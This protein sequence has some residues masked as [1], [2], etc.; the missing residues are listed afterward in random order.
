[1]VNRL[2]GGLSIGDA[3]S[4]ATSDEG[5]AM[6]ATLKRMVERDGSPLLQIMKEAE[7]HMRKAEALA[8]RR[9][10]TVKQVLDASLQMYEAQIKTADGR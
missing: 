5:K 9:G 7:E 2:L 6:I 1:M 10:V 3:M 8:K 4:L